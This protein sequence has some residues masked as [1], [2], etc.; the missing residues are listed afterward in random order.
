[1]QFIK[2]NP[3][4]D[5]K[6][7]KIVGA[8]L[9]RHGHQ[10]HALIEAL[11]VVQDAFGYLDEK[12]LRYVAESLR[13]PYSKAFGV[14]TFYHHFSLKPQGAH[15]CVVCTGTACH[16]KGG[17]ALLDEVK[18]RYEVQP[19]GTRSDGSLSVVTARCLGACGLAPVAVFDQEVVGKLEV[20]GLRGRI[21]PWI[22]SKPS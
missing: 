12:A 10:S 15:T 19:G 2:P 20:D 11:H 21:D 18:S 6:R 9:R 14:A 4:S 5:D 3:P 8:T 7:W 22:G 16:I 13:V 17:A 1:M